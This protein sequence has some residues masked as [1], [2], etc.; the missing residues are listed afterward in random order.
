MKNALRLLFIFIG[1]SVIMQTHK[2]STALENSFDPEYEALMLAKKER[3]QKAYMNHS[4]R[5]PAVIHLSK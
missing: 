4:G 1:L 5:A 2:E 3:L